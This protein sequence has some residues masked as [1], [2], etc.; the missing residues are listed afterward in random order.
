MTDAT[1]K[2]EDQQQQRHPPPFAA[3]GGAPKTP[4]DYLRL[5]AASGWD[6]KGARRRGIAEAF[7]SLFAF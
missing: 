6:A 4:L 1:E 2:A 5:G 7:R 3:S